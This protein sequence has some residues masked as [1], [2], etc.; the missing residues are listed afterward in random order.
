MSIKDYVDELH[1]RQITFIVHEKDFKNIGYW[2]RSI[3]SKLK[4]KR[5]LN[6]DINLDIS[7]M[8]GEE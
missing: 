6:I 1:K 3:K 4:G 7:Y 8:E 2:L 5:I